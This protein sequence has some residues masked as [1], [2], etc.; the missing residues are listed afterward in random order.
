MC[1]GRCRR[2]GGDANRRGSST[3]RPRL[4]IY[5][6]EY[7]G[8]EVRSRACRQPAFT[9][10]SGRSGMLAGRDRTV[11]LDLVGRAEGR[12][13]RLQIA[14]GRVRSARAAAEG[15]GL[16]PMLSC[17][18]TACGVATC[19]RQSEQL[20]RRRDRRSYAA[21]ASAAASS[22]TRV[23][24][25]VRW[26]LPDRRLAPWSS[27]PRRSGM[28]LPAPPWLFP[29]GMIPPRFRCAPRH[30]H[31]RCS[32]HAR[33]DRALPVRFPFRVDEC[34]KCSGRRCASRTWT[35]PSRPGPPRWR[36][37]RRD[38]GPAGAWDDPGRR[39][40]RPDPVRARD[41]SELL[42][43]PQT[44]RIVLRAGRPIDTT[45]PDHRELDEL[46]I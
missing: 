37:P 41:W 5:I 3:P 24:R 31:A 22:S 44:E 16:P 7:L 4:C 15:T 27:R 33:P 23:A 9:L 39:P 19:L 40:G 32:R 43:R 25:C 28:R 36:A 20:L 12:R 2:G 1:R 26:R 45:L 46:M 21:A 35:A 29:R 38:H 30:A 11:I 8:G 14:R 17:R 34:S 13:H 42:S 18:E 6:R 10:P